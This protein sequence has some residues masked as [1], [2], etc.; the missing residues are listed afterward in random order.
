MPGLSRRSFLT[1]GSI[2][3]A[4]G[5]VASAVPGLG[6]LLQVSEEDA[7]GVSG[8]A[9]DAGTAGAEMTSPLVAHVKDLQ[10]GEI[11]LY[12]GEQQ[13]I[14]KDPALAARLYRASR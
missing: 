9:T 12:Q 4:V 1:R 2:L 13:V 3:V 11:S 7:P 6:S 14:Y 8:A 5:S 10:T